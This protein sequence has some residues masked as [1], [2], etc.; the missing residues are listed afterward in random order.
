MNRAR[1]NAVIDSLAFICGVFMIATG[2]ILRYRLPPGSGRLEGSGFGH[3][4][5]ARPVSL[6]WGLT[7]HEWGDI[8]YGVALGL[9]S[10]LS[11]HLVLH[12]RWIFCMVRGPSAERSRTRIAMGLL[13]FLALISLAAGPLLSPIVK[14]GRGE[15]H[16]PRTVETTRR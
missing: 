8:H 12:W 1:L 9:L 10:V 6:V 14:I 2:F 3:D 16:Y 4:A 11:L 13:A 15:F 5:M 7:R